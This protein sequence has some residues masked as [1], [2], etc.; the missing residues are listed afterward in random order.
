MLPVLRTATS[1]RLASVRCTCAA[2]LIVMLSLLLGA[3]SPTYVLRSGY[4]E[5]KILWRRQA[6]AQLLARPD[7]DPTLRT[8]LEL[9]L[10]VR[11]FAQERLKLRVGGSYSSYARIDDNQTVYVVTA[12]E[13]LRLRS[14]TWWFPI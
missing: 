13:R 12:A 11:R 10:A 1:G 6:I 14:Y 8:K 2:A 9:V 7:L 3:C 5:A 4:E